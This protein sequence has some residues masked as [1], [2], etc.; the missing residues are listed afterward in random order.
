MAR[1]C[2]GNHAWKAYYHEHRCECGCGC[3]RDTLGYAYCVPCEFECSRTVVGL[4]SHALT[5]Y[6]RAH[7]R[8]KTCS[9]PTDKLMFGYLCGDCNT[10]VVEQEAQS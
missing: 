3:K 6:E 7:G 10:R 2:N 8:G 5:Y 9:H 4:A 1:I